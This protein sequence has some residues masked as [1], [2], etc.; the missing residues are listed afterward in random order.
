[1]QDC[2][3]IYWICRLW[4]GWIK[5]SLWEAL[6]R[7]GALLRLKN[8]QHTHRRPNLVTKALN[9]ILKSGNFVNTASL[10]ERNTTWTG[11]NIIEPC[12]MAGWDIRGS[13]ALMTQN[14]HPDMTRE[15][16]YNPRSP[17][18][19]S[20]LLSPFFDK[21]FPRFSH[22]ICSTVKSHFQR[23]YKF[24]FLEWDEESL[25]LIY[26]MMERKTHRRILFKHFLYL[27]KLKEILCLLFN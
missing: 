19:D 15:L 17:A 2:Q 24:L 11:K 9:L 7:V 14:F 21:C 25:A 3:V 12:E 5:R 13:G 6:I 1:M 4:K 22:S 18:Q 23:Y 20:H 16:V 8:V 26:E 27:E 10:F